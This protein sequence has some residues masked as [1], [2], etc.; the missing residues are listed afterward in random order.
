VKNAGRTL[1]LAAVATLPIL[2]AAAAAGAPDCGDP[3]WSDRPACQTTT[4]TPIPVAHACP[5][6]PKVG[7]PSII[8]IEGAGSETF[9]CD[10]SPAYDASRQSGTV[11]VTV[12]AGEVSRLVVFVRDSNPGDICVLKEWDRPSSNSFEVSFPLVLGDETYWQHA[13]N[14]C[15]RFDPVAG[16]RDDLNGDPL[17]LSVNVRGKKGTSVEVTLTPG[18]AP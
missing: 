14:W 16:T 11:N 9:E 2:V 3:K 4:T 8:T 6:A 1:I 13:T 10:W 17:H 7:D 18:Q 12:D 15:S 5:A